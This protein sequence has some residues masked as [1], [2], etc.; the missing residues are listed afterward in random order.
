MFLSYAIYYPIAYCADKAEVPLPVYA[1]NIY[2]YGLFLS[3]VLISLGLAYK[4]TNRVVRI[5]VYWSSV[6][7]WSSLFTIYL[8]D[9]L[10]PEGSFL[11]SIVHTNKIIVALIIVI[12]ICFCSILK[13]LRRG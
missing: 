8:I 11:D 13:P 3:L 6:H 4:E 7:F 1:Y 10:S 5:M 12:A 9:D 2:Q